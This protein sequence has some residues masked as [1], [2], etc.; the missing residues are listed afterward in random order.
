MDFLELLLF[1][2]PAYFSNSTPVVLGGGKPLDLGKTLWDGRRVFG[3]SKTI[4]GLLS[5]L[6]VGTFVSIPLSLFPQFLPGFSLEQ[7][8]TVAFLV[9]LGAMIGDLIGSFSKRRLGFGEGES[10]IVTDQLLFLAV[11]LLLSSTYVKIGLYD[12][13]ALVVVTFVLHV[14]FNQI[15]HRLGLKKVPW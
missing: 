14:L 6:V 8:I 4:R 12:I 11:A 3:A 10:F 2:L 5:A 7:K 15:A 13:V 1:I 9:S